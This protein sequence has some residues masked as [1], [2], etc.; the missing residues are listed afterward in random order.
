M[1]VPCTSSGSHMQHA[2]R[3]CRPEQAVPKM[4]AC[5]QLHALS[6]AVLLEP[7]EHNAEPAAVSAML[8]LI[9]LTIG[10]SKYNL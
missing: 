4:Y 1:S 6:V 7:W 3:N 5:A 10:P 9:T 2:H 8:Q